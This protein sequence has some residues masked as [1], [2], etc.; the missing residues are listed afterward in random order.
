M[1][2]QESSKNLTTIN[3][4]CSIIELIGKDS[5]VFL[6]N[7]LISDLTDF[8]PD[9]IY[10]TALCNPKGRIIATLWIKI[11]DDSQILLI[12]PT[13]LSDWLLTF[14]NARKFRLKINISYSAHKTVLNQQQQTID[15]APATDST[16]T[17]TST[18]AFYQYIFDNNYP[19]IDTNNTEQFI[20]QHVNLD[21]HKNIMSFTKG[22]YPGQE[23]I[24]RI[25][26][27]GKIKKRMQLL[28]NNNKQN[29][30]A[31]IEQ[32]QA[33]SPIIYNKSNDLYQVQVIVKS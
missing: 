5:A 22:C 30:L 7:F 25:K 13:N 10:Y 18:E 11:I 29:L 2:E 15:I 21:Q 24:A 6:N 32:H 9:Q 3:S 26:Y 20:P 8:V 28:N 31:D 12:C 14:F 19:W 17:E 16:T 4:N 23:I 1:C 27:L 33:V